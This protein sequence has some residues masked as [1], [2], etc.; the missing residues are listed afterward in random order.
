[1]DRT[2]K[3][4]LILGVAAFFILSYGSLSTSKEMTDD[5]RSNFKG[6]IT[7]LISE[8]TK[9]DDFGTSKVQV[10]EVAIEEKDGGLKTINIENDETLISNARIFKEG[11]KI[12]VTH[13]RSQDGVETYYISDYLRNNV[14]I[15]LFILFILVVLVVTRWQGLGSILGMAISFLVIF[16]LILPLILSG[17]NP[18]YAAILGSLIIIPSTFYFSHGINRK[19]SVAVGGTLLTLIVTGL[20]ATFF[21]KI[22]HLTGLS[23]EE[24]TFL[25]I[26]TKDLIDFRGLVLAGMMISILGILDDITISQASVIQQLKNTKTGIKFT[27]LYGR[28]MTVGSDHIA[29][30]VNTLIL[31]YT[32]ASLPLLLV[33]MN[34]SEQFSEVINYE[35][36]AQEVIETLVGSIGLIMAVPI[37][38]LLAC[39]LIKKTKENI[40]EHNHS[41]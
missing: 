23:T 1:M 6:E 16:K 27:E 20:L 17:T 14:L 41:H 40:N 8:E 32:G 3:T 13:Y 18:I 39:I 7:K 10:L 4:I 9:T 2:S 12:L 5:G 29:S 36:I 26:E 34:H 28:G 35:F 21:A 30:M 15:W 33:F 37:T 38:T 24:L 11:D 22:G 31:V 25:K 19:T